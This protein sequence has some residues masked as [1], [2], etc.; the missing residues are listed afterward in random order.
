MKGM[1]KCDESNDMDQCLNDCGDDEE[2]KKDCQV[3][4][5][6]KPDCEIGIYLC[7]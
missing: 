3:D 2:C 1:Y 5:N 6:C 7:N 4:E